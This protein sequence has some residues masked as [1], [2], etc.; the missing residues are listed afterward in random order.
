MRR[1]VLSFY[2][3]FGAVAVIAVHAKQRKTAAES[4]A[5]QMYISYEHHHGDG[6]KRMDRVRH[7]VADGKRWVHSVE[8]ADGGARDMLW[9]DVECDSPGITGGREW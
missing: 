9:M 7:R 8:L 1:C 5:G 6:W 4:G 3:A 2:V